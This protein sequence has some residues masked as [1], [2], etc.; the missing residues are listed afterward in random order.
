MNKASQTTQAWA[1]WEIYTYKDVHK[2]PKYSI[3]C[4]AIEEGMQAFV[5]WGCH[6]YELN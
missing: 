4:F 1:V 5:S 3:P 2:P 6:V